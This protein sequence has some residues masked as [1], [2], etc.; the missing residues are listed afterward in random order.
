MSRCCIRWQHKPERYTR[1]VPCL[2]SHQGLAQPI[3]IIPGSC[4]S[5]EIQELRSRHQSIRETPQ[6]SDFERLLLGML[7]ICKREL[8]RE[9]SR[10]KRLPGA[11]TTTRR[12]EMQK[13]G[14]GES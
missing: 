8:R 14:Q 4:D 9:Q 6:R 3:E 1:T 12:I 13:S 2:S 7:R 10:R 5:C 11:Y